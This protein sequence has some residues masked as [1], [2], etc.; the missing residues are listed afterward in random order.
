MASLPFQTQP[1]T[2]RTLETLIRLSTAHAKARMSKLVEEQDAESAINLVNFAYFKKVNPC[3][4]PH[5]ILSCHSH[6]H[7]TVTHTSCHRHPHLMPQSP[8][9]HGWV[10]APHF[11]PHSM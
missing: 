4:H 7:A 8:T 10:T 1:V 2:A 6:Y 9:P 5:L 3:S 11:V